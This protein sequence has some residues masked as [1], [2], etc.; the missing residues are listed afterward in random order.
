M[1]IPLRGRACIY[2]GALLI[3][4][5]NCEKYLVSKSPSLLGEGL[6]WGKS[7]LLLVEL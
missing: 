3:D 7:K 6:G 2:N 1:G 5:L 4:V